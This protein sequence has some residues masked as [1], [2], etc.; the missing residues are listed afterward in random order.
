MSQPL[1]GIEI[2]DLTVGSWSPSPDA[3]GPP[4]AVAL[5]LKAL[6][7]RETTVDL[8][9]RLKTPRAVDDL[10]AALAKH[11]ADVWPQSPPAL[12]RGDEDGLD[13][14]DYPL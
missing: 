13:C 1:M 3:S 4:E 10:I 8:V 12:D 9:L 7:N 14:R 2:I 6:W 11:K 5:A